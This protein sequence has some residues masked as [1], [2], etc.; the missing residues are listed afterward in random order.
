MAVAGLVVRLR[1]GLS[2]YSGDRLRDR[3]KGG[4]RAACSN[5]RYQS[6]VVSGRA[7]GL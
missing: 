1:S 7:I 3:K 5:R 2:F 6:V 4:K